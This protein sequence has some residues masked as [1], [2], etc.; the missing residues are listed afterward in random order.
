MTREEIIDGLEIYT[1]GKLNKARAHITVEELQK[2]IDA[3][4]ALEQ[5]PCDDAK[6]KKIDEWE[7]KGKIAELWIVNGNLQVRYLGTI[8]SIP[9]L[10]VNLQEPKIGKW[11]LIDKELSRYKCSECGE[12]IKLYKK[13]EI[14]N[15]EKDEILSDYPFSHCGA[16]MTESEVKK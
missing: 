6:I 9:L 4:K 13:S 15:L 1:V 5:E 16:K 8:H 14:L 2:F 3:I 11:I 7:I 10:S 12:V